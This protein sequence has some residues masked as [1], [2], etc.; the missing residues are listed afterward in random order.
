MRRSRRELVLEWMTKI[1]LPVCH[2]V[3]RANSRRWVQVMFKGVSRLGDGWFWG[4]AALALFAVEGR[5][6]LPVI[7]RLAA[8][9]SVCLAVYKTIKARTRRLRPCAVDEN[10]LETVPPLDRYSFP[11]GHT[12]HAV[13]MSIVI[14]ATYPV[15]AWVLIPFALLVAASRLILGLHYP[16]DVAVGAIIGMTVALGLLQL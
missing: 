15:L 5:E 8:V 2:A 9:C 4:I 13:A 16:S 1:E 14:V 12:M 10:I 6:C 3:N 11:S 7:L